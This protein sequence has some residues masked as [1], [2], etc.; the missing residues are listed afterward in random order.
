MLHA[1]KKGKAIKSGRKLW[2]VSFTGRIYGLIG[3]RRAGAVLGGPA[4]RSVK[5]SAPGFRH[6]EGCNGLGR[7][8]KG[9]P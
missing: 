5:A 8:K 4:G 2:N 1:S 6:H 9:P 3:G 7:V